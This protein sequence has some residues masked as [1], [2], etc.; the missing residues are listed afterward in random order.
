MMTVVVVIMIGVDYDDC[1]DGFNDN[2]LM[3]VVVTIM[4]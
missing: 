1:E 4:F 3:M 2:E